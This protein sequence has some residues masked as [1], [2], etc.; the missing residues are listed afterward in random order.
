MNAPVHN[1]LQA[2]RAHISFI[3]ERALAYRVH[4]CLITFFLVLAAFSGPP[5]SGTAYAI[6]SSFAS[7]MVFIYVANKVTDKNEDS[8]NTHAGT[9]PDSS[10]PSALLFAFVC[11]ILP[12]A[13][14]ASLKNLILVAV[15]LVVF[16]L[17]YLYSFPITWYGKHF[18]LKQILFVKN[19]TSALIW[20][21]PP[22]GV[23]IA[24]QDR[25]DAYALWWFAIV[26]S[27]SVTI[28][29][30]W[31]VR[32][33]KGDDQFGVR[34]IANTYGVRTAQAS[35]LAF[36]GIAAFAAYMTGSGAYSFVAIALSAVF[37]LSVSERRSAWF[38]HASAFVWLI[39]L[40]L[41]TANL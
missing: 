28:E 16:V 32:D 12:L 2:L 13:Y 1:R 25:A 6:A 27:I 9:I 30:L 8:V 39:I 15:Y 5:Y 19:C 24:M 29:I 20:A 23:Y 37:V 14:L 34:T 35:S 26:F 38:F 11:A 21:L 4:V 40:V 10:R 22:I 33:M 7:L 36:L 31:D 3:V 18:R 41:Q 17:G